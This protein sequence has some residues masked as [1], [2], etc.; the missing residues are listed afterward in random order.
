MARRR[1]PRIPVRDAQEK[2]KLSRHYRATAAQRLAAAREHAPVL[3]ALA[4]VMGHAEETALRA[5]LVRHR[6]SLT[7][8]S[9]TAACALRACSEWWHLRSARGFGDPLPG[10]QDEHDDFWLWARELLKHG[11]GSMALQLTFTGDS[12]ADILRQVTKLAHEGLEN[13]PS[14][15]ADLPAGRP[16]VDATRLVA[17][18]PEKTEI[19]ARHVEHTLRS[20]AAKF[21]E[22]TVRKILAGYGAAKVSELGPDTYERVAAECRLL[23]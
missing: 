9:P 8:D 2:S 22:D 7:V 11:G 13:V 16:S 19:T 15:A 5:W 23:F 12:L 4:R 3:A 21:G 20:V 17:P 6:A 1:A 18:A 14:H 10:E